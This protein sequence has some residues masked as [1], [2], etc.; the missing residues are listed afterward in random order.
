ITAWKEFKSEPQKLNLPSAPKLPVQYFYENKYPQ[1]KIHRN[2]EKGMA[3]AVGR[4]R[5][6]SLFD[7]K[8]VV[9]SHNTVRGAAGGT[10]LIAELMKSK[11]L[12][13]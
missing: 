9:L 1:P 12:L 7:F 6:D 3:V 2:L 11:G 8:F 10:I 5:E 4:L 13:G